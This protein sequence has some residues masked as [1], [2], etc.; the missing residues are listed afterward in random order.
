MMQPL[1]LFD[2]LLNTMLEN[3]G[4]FRQNGNITLNLIFT[5]QF[6][7]YWIAICCRINTDLD[8]K[9]WLMCLYQY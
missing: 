3:V 8:H 4:E 7:Q 9:L 5:K 2:V 1:N 6:D